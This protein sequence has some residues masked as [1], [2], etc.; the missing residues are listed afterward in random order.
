MKNEKVLT[1]IERQRANKLY[2]YLRLHDTITKEEACQV[3][4]VNER[5]AREVLSLVAYKMPII[6]TSD[7]KGYRLAKT[8]EDL[9]GVEHT[10]AE[11]RSR[12]EEIEK[13]LAPLYAFR[14]RARGVMANDSL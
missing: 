13:R 4:G 11:L 14:D 10:A 7:S 9:N 2:H 5:T 8:L 6:A 3:L 12:M 1:E